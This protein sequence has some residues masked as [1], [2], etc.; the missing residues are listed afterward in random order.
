[1]TIAEKIEVANRVLAYFAQDT[2][3]IS[4]LN[5]SNKKILTIKW[6]LYN[7]KE[8]EKQWMT[9]GQDFYPVW[10]N[11]WAHGGTSCIAL[12]QL[13]RWIK[14]RPVLGIESWRYWAKDNVK[15][16]SNEAVD[17][18]E[19]NGYPIKTYCVL[20]GNETRYNDWWSLN[21]LSGPC[22]NWNS[23]CRQKGSND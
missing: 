20:C 8:Y 15:L 2:E 14:D 7:G 19:N 3:I 18:L 13:I 16:L 17:I 4:K 22:C 5:K 23:G 11:K 10:Y 21:K 9:R 12:S 1:M 6:K